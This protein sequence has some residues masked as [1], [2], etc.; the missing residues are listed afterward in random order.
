MDDQ[1]TQTY[2]DWALDLHQGTASLGVIN[3][4]LSHIPLSSISIGLL[5]FGSAILDFST[6]CAF[7]CL[8]S[9][10]FGVG[11]HIPTLLGLYL[12]CAVP[13]IKSLF[14]DWVKQEPL[15]KRVSLEKPGLNS[16]AFIEMKGAD[17]IKSGHDQL[18]S[19]CHKDGEKTV[20]G[21]IVLGTLA[22]LGTVDLAQNPVTNRWLLRPA[23]PQIIFDM[24]GDRVLK[25]SDPILL[26]ETAKFYKINN[27][28]LDSHQTCLAEALI[29]YHDCDSKQ[30]CCMPGLLDEPDVIDRLSNHVWETQQKM[31]HGA[32]PIV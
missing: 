2:P 29:K 7:S 27:V 32:F 28:V 3:Y 14:V 11:R 13:S 23:N 19:F 21:G 30:K 6:A 15:E 20:I 18:A 25:I 22:E 17:L 31:A 8:F 24:Y 10:G 4:G 9:I 26:D 5:T 12:P 16:E 1:Q